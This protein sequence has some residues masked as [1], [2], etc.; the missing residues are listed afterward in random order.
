MR[1]SLLLLLCLVWVHG[2]A[3]QDPAAAPGSAYIPVR[4]YDASRNAAQDIQAAQAEA[5]RTAKRVLVQVGGAGAWCDWCHFMDTF[6]QTHPELVELR[7]RYFVTVKVSVSVENQNK[8]VLSQYPK[9]FGYP[10]FFVLDAQGKLLQSQQTSQLEMGQGN[11]YDPQKVR[12][13]LLDWGEQKNAGNQ[14]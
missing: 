13:F 11:T 12:A 7:D 10:H 2:S 6:F 5:R 9:I 8:E 3:R 14:K 4:E 1:K